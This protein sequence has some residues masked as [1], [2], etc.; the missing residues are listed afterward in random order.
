MLVRAR[1]STGPSAAP[2][3]LRTLPAHGIRMAFASRLAGGA[4]AAS[5]A[6]VEEHL[7]WMVPEAV[8][9]VSAPCARSTT[10]SPLG[11]FTRQVAGGLAHSG[12]RRSSSM[13]PQSADCADAELS[14]AG[15]QISTGRAD[16]RAEAPTETVKDVIYPAAPGGYKT[17]PHEKRPRDLR[18]GST[19]SARSMP[20][21]PTTTAGA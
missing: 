1:I 9:A 18:A 21:P 6:G 4:L 14:A 3:S 13:A 17:L 8:F 7:S 20:P 16:E 10:M 15:W 11:E 5:G 2:S 12:I 19:S